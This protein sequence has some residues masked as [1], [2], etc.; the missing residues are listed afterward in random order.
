MKQYVTLGM[1]A[2]LLMGLPQAR[3]QQVLKFAQDSVA[4][5]IV[6]PD[7][8]DGTNE[9]TVYFGIVNLTSENRQVVANRLST[10]LTAGHG[11]FFCWDLC[12]D[13]T[14]DASLNPVTI[15][16]NDTTTFGQYTVL[17]PNNL[18]GQSEVT[19][20]FTDVLTGVSIQR[21]YVFKVGTTGR[22]P[23]EQQPWLSAP[24]PNPASGHTAVQVGL[25]PGQAAGELL[26]RDLQGRVLR[27]W[28]VGPQPD[29]QPLDL[30]GVSAGWYVLALQTG[31]GTAAVQ[32]LLVR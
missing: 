8:T 31:Q 22:T 28:R 7:G 20:I 19:M 2:A 32:R 27:S 14:A 16:A 17:K 6:P 9:F 13:S 25:P 23:L 5:F 12:Y 4:A 26:L 3:A 15:N 18:S 29:R 10:E 11:N 21:T 30:N 24:Q 1:M